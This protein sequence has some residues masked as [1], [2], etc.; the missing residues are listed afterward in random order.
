MLVGN[1]VSKTVSVSVTG[2]ETLSIAA[3]SSEKSCT[4]LIDLFS[5]EASWGFVYPLLKIPD[6]SNPD[7]NPSSVP[8][9]PVIVSGTF[10]NLSLGNTS[11][12]ANSVSSTDLSPKPED[13]L[14]PRLYIPSP[15]CPAKSK[16]NPPI[17]RNADKPVKLSGKNSPN[18]NK[19]G[20]VDEK[21]AF[22]SPTTCLKTSCAAGLYVT[23]GFCI[24]ASKAVMS[25][26]L[27]I[28]TSFV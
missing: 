26:D 3:I 19:E 22:L 18:L 12:G 8:G 17:S 23:S 25:V 2:V 21:V 4:S 27:S 10:G 15:T 20:S 5:I 6:S 16:P 14:L 7:I 24:K 1:S 9:L 11:C 13:T 28:G